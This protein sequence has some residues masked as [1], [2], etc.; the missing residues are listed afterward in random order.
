LNCHNVAKHTG[1]TWDSYSSMWL[2]L[3]MQCFKRAL[4]WYSKCYFVA[5][6]M[7]TFT[8][9]GYNTSFN[10]LN[11]SFIIVANFSCN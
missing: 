3:V 1:F 11:M 10:T 9:K 8:H 6:V 2:S 4:Q 7:K 5:N